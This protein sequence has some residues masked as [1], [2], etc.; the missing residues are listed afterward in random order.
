M[1]ILDHDPAAMDRPHRTPDGE[2]LLGRYRN[3]LIRPLIQGY[4]ISHKRK[5]QGAE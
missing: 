5:R 1:T 4:V 3:E 2:A